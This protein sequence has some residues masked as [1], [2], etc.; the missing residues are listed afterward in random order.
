MKL[1]LETEKDDDLFHFPLALWYGEGRVGNI[2]LL[3][4]YAVGEC[5]YKHRLN[6]VVH[7]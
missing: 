2:Y 1:D 6:E 5:A 7:Y 4:Q 3:L